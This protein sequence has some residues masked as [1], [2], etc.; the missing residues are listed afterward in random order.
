MSL[1]ADR[2]SALLRE[3]DTLAARLRAADKEIRGSQAEIARLRAEIAL[4]RVR[5]E[6]ATA[7][8]VR[9]AVASGSD[10]AASAW[11]LLDEAA[12]EMQVTQI[13]LEAEEGIR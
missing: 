8:A 7:T 12:D 13:R 9:I 2:V 3:R 4:C 10:L 6:Q 5:V 11:T 1:P